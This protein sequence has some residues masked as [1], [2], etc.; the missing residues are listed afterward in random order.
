MGELPAD[1]RRLLDA[2][3]IAHIATLMA[4]GSPHSVPVWV[5]LEGDEIAVMTSPRS[6]KAR[7]LGRDPR[8]A[9]SITDRDQ[10]TAMAGVRGRINDVVRGERGW[11]IID[12]ISHKYIG[13][14]Y[15]LREDRVV[16]MIDVDHA[17]AYNFG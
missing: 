14:P 10:P 16:F 2:A 9:L 3:N 4:D 5:G 13:Q 6:Q 12:R 15:P 8:V 1:A 17:F 11:E 7:N